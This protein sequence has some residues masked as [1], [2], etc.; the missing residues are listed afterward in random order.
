M[1]ERKNNLDV[2]KF[3]CAFLIVCIHAPFTGIGGGTLLQ[4][5]EQV[6]RSF[7]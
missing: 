6:F 1:A 5:Q 4:L 2:L 3:V 7:L